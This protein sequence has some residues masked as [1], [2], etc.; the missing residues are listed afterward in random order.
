M[1]CNTHLGVRHEGPVRFHRYPQLL[2]ALSNHLFEVL[3]VLQELPFQPLALRDVLQRQHRPCETAQASDKGRSGHADLHLGLAQSQVT[4][5]YI[6]DAGGKGGQ[7]V[8]CS[9]PVFHPLCQL[10][11]HL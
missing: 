2:R 9:S 10:F 7:Q 3:L 8:H 11:K 1:D 6:M 4:L 5:H